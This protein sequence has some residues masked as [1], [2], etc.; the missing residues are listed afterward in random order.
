LFDTLLI[1]NRGEIACRVIRTA[2]RLGIRTVAIYSDADANA[3]HTTSA[4]EAIHVGPSAA[5]D[6]YLNIPR[7]IEAALTTGAQAIHP[8][9]GFLSENA[10]FAD[11]CAEAGIV[12]VGPSADSIRSMGSKIEAK[13]RISAAGT[14]VVPGYH[15]DDQREEA[16]TAAARDVGYPLMIKASAGGG[17]KGMRIVHSAEDFDAALAGARREAQ[18]AFGEDRVLLERYLSAPKHIEVQILAD[19]KGTTLYLFERDCSVQRR[20]QKVIEEAPAPG[21][22]PEL[23]QRLGESAVAAAR[24]IDYLG[25]GTVEFIAEGDEFYFMEM[26]T[27]LQV[28]HPVTEAITGLDLVEWQLRVAGGEALPFAQSDLQINGHALE[29]RVYA[30]NPARRFLPSTGVLEHLRFP[31]QARVDTGVAE[32]S[33][34]SVHYDPMLA[35]IITHGANRHQAMERMS[36]ALRN[37]EIAGI[38]HN[39][40]YLGAVIAD[41]GFISGGYTTGLADQIHASVVPQTTPEHWILASLAALS[42][43]GS[44]W[45]ATD[46]FRINQPAQTNLTLKQGKQQGVVGWVNDQV[47]VQD[48]GFIVTAV[49]CSADNIAARIDGRNWHAGYRRIDDRVHLFVA[50]HTI[51][52]TLPDCHVRAVDQQAAGS[53]Q[54]ASPMPGQ[55]I[56]V[57]V[58]PGDNVRTGDV[59]MIV[60]A[61]KMEHEIKAACSGRVVELLC[62]EGGKVDDGQELIRIEEK[63]S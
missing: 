7:I 28:E 45:Q 16:L 58:N 40:G 36:Q 44:P 32:N 53:G 52:F 6:S 60:E 3:V 25:A 12:F 50:G 56:R 33:E 41:P 24:A 39:V 42:Q 34:V 59:L 51:T 8:G 15:E 20:H 5:K 30:E 38:E 46:G 48:T 17:G 62:S 14:P 21:V 29:V 19:A 37:T 18:A 9:Y 49:E 54:M 10:E 11:A 43:G 57:L 22:T 35:K 31:D 55:V 1:A 23:R 61:M 2:R 47:Q 63:A 27:R 26:N 13:R 4:D